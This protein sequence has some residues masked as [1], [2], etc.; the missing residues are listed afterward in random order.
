MELG[1]LSHSWSLMS[2]LQGNLQGWLDTGHFQGLDSQRFWDM[3]ITPLSVL[4]LL[5][6]ALPASAPLS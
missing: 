6:H 4:F 2:Y 3:A 5:S 1:C